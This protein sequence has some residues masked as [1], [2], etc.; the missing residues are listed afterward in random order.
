M[1]PL[2]L[3][4]AARANGVSALHGD[5]SRRMWEGLWPGTP[6]GD[7]PI[8]HVTNGVHARTWLS[9]ELQALLDASGVRPAEAPAEQR[10]DRVAE[11]DPVEIWRVHRVRKR[12]LGEIVAAR[13][14]R[15]VDPEALTIGFARRFATYKRANLLFSQPER[16]ARLLAEPH[17]PLQIVIAGKAHPQDDAGK[18]VIRSVLAASRELR[19]EGRVIF[20]EDYD[21][22]LARALIAGVDVW[23]N[24]PRRPMEASGTSGMKAGMNGVL[25]CSVLDGWWPE[26]YTP[27]IGW[28]V[29][30]GFESPVEEEQDGHD[31][32]SLFRLLEE[33]VVPAF[34]DRDPG[35]VP[36][37]WVAMMKA[38]IAAVGTTFNTHRMVAEYAEQY[39]LPAHRE[40]DAVRATAHAA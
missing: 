5:V 7:V 9:T 39:Y 19:A 33:E 30:E 22:E 6:A 35:G 13:A 37:R 26:A 29:G 32:E 38:S 4:S 18:S 20:V 31:R 21:M 15:F 17:R 2:A 36:E 1:T 11:I 10:W 16:L 8:G 12:V 14:R 3:R 25:N 23:L 40:A 28:A 27:E 34:Y 24:T